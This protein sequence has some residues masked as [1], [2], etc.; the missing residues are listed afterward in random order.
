MSAGAGITDQGLMHATLLV[1]GLVIARQG[2]AIRENRRLVEDQR[3]DLVA[4]ISHELRTPLTAVVGFLDV[5]DHGAIE[6][7]AETRE[8]TSIA[9]EQASYLSRIVSDL[10]MLASENFGTMTLDV[11]PTDV[12]ELA[13]SSVTA[14]ALDPPGVRV[15][16][17]RGTTAFLDGGRMRQALGN[18]V[19]NA[20]RYGG[21]HTLVVARTDGG[22]LLLEVHDDGPRSSSQV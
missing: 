11:A 17:E 18:L 4:S 10:V 1:G 21:G 13:W 3:T 12:D 7:A 8:I 16:A 20:E 5:L 19:A 6:D 14:A 15:D 22:D 2:V 9:S